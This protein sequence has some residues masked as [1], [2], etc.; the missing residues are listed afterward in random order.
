M[1]DT[2]APVAQDAVA[3]PLDP[4]QLYSQANNALSRCM[5]EMNAEQISF[6]LVMRHLD[7]AMN[8]CRALRD[9]QTAQLH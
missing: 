7:A 1:A 8:A 5:R 3:S 2:F 6:A 9:L 4:I